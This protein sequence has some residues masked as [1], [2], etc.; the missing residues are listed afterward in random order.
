MIPIKH[1][2]KEIKPT[3][4]NQQTT[5]H[6]SFPIYNLFLLVLNLLDRIALVAAAHSVPDLWESGTQLP[7]YKSPLIL[8]S[9]NCP[10]W[11]VQTLLRGWGERGVGGGGQQHDRCFSDNTGLWRV[12]GVGGGVMF[13]LIS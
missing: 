5:P 13:E 6:F 1:L 7:E 10:E 9:L 8:E 2:I 11:S 12:G 3:A 4:M